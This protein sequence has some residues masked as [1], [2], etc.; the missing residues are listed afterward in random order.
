MK[1][2][3]R[4]FAVTCLLLFSLSAIGDDHERSKNFVMFNAGTLNVE[5]S[6]IDETSRGT[7]GHADA[8]IYSKVVD[9]KSPT[10]ECPYGIVI[11]KD[12]IVMTFNDLSQL[13]GTAD[14][15]VCIEDGGT[16]SIDGKGEWVSGSRRFADVTGGEL[17]I[18][19]TATPQSDY[20]PFYT[21]A[22]AISGQIER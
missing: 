4:A 18:K 17:Y 16:Q 19:G 11:T 3:V 9:F 20:G 15:N 1:I 13:V 21:T 8:K 22:G 7:L 14:T 5:A 6:I 10:D 2:I 12:S